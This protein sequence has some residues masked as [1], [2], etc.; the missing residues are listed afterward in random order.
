MYSHTLI[1]IHSPCMLSHTCTHIFTYSCTKPHTYIHK[2]NSHYA[3]IITTLTH[4]Y[5]HALIHT[6]NHTPSQ[7][8]THA[9]V[10]PHHPG[11]AM[12]STCLHTCAQAYRHSHVL[13]Q[14]HWQYILAHSFTHTHAQPHTYNHQKLP[15]FPPMPSLK[16][17]Q[18]LLDGWDGRD[19]A[20]LPL[21]HAHHHHGPGQLLLTGMVWL[22][23]RAWIAA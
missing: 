12:H 3:H 9:L 15:P 5:T 13:C 1:H 14:T 7:R 11:V 2:H 4:T 19:R 6:H 16:K 8:H 20:P 21:F 22:P 18:G 17:R 23:C 10:P